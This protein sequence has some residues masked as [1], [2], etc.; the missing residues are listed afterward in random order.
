VPSNES[1]TLGKLKTVKRRQPR[2]KKLSSTVSNSS[3]LD[4]ISK[5]QAIVE[6]P[7]SAGMRYPENPDDVSDWVQRRA[8]RRR[9]PHYAPP[10][11]D[12]SSSSSS[13]TTS[14]SSVL[15]SEIFELPAG[16]IAATPENPA[17][18]EDED[19]DDAELRA[20]IALS[21][22]DT[23]LN[24]REGPFSTLQAELDA[25]LERSRIEQ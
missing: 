22:Q 18:A 16:N 24:G 7:Q 25:A 10:P 2:R 15:H 1:P 17:A 6:K 12:T 5:M 3:G 13:R 4:E 9:L 19:E 8:A 20:A 14:L 23:E 11:V 21:L